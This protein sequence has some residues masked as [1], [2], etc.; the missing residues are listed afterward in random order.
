M[1]AKCYYCNKE[2]TEK[3]IKKH[4]KNCSEMIK[5][6]DEKIINDRKQIDQFIISIKPK[7]AGNEY[8]IYLSI[9]GILGLIHIDQFIR[10]I[11]V[12]C[13]GHLSGFKI[14][15]EYY[16][17]DEMN[18]QL[19]DILNIDEKFEYEY[20]FGSTTHLILEVVDIIKVPSNFSQIEIIARNDEVKHQCEICGTEARYFNYESDRWECENCV[21]DDGDMIVEFDYCNSPRDGVCGYEG[22]KEAENTYLPGNDKEY[23][24]T[25]INIKNHDNYE[26][27][28]DYDDVLSNMENAFGDL[29]S[30]SKNIMN[31][32]F[33]KGIYSFNI[34]ELISNL[35]KDNIY[36][37]AK[38]LGMT[39]ISSLN[40]N[41]LVEKLL[42]EYEVLIEKRMY[43]FDDE[44]YKI[45]KSYADN[46]GVKLVDKIDE[47][48][49]EKM[50]YFMAN[51]M[52]FSSL[53]DGKQLL[54]M[55]EV[56][57]RLVKEKNN[58]EYRNIIKLNNE[59]VSIYR[60]MNR[61]YGILT[62]DV[63][64]EL[65]KRYAPYKE[66]AQRIENSAP[67]KEGT[68]RIE[69][70]ALYESD[71]Y[72]IEAVIKE[73]KDYYQEYELEA[74]GTYFVNIDVDDWV[75]LSE[76][77]DDEEPLDYAMISKEEIMSMAEENWIHQSNVGKIFSNEFLEIFD[78]DRDI[79]ESIIESLTLDIQENE[80]EDVVADLMEEL[81]DDN[82]E[83]REFICN[84]IRKFL[85]DIRLWRYKGATINEKKG[86]I[87]K[88]EKKKPVGRNENCLCGSGK[89]YKN[90]CA[91]NGN[92]IKL[93]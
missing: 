55:P 26:S 86:A 82:G 48:D 71:K 1:K 4:M 52:L 33:A 40:K 25:K 84:S 44:R 93:F 51:G 70:N 64:K 74:Q 11:W 69:N 37:I 22:H 47:D 66:S 79:L 57:Q 19:N 89:K 24:L 67:Y 41:K 78:M 32:F 91:K 14:K 18:I 81:E 36:D 49:I 16:Q 27:K 10:N 31:N 60:G 50:I 34:N 6:I 61:A 83:I 76:Q 87:I 58:L 45:L 88:E 72:Q 35:S 75:N 65:F 13:C 23:K 30:R 43:L 39:K 85:R 68:Q 3:T 9:S 80:L 77:L 92:V 5:S 62:L 42:N 38:Y 59:I 20:D 73:L 15:G 63:I 8:C 46:G 12:E 17:N 54:L 90:C 53:K 56:V 28:F 7:Y 29:L 21:D 2:L